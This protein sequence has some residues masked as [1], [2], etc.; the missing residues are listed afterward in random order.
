MPFHRHG[1]KKAHS[2]EPQRQ[3]RRLRC[4]PCLRCRGGAGSADGQQEDPAPGQHS[5]DAA[6]RAQA[7]TGSLLCSG[8]LMAPFCPERR[9]LPAFAGASRNGRV[10]PSDCT[11]SL[12]NR[13]APDF[14][15]LERLLLG[16]F[17]LAG[18][19]IAMKSLQHRQHGKL[20]RGMSREAFCLRG[21]GRMKCFCR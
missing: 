11:G 10:F 2:A 13:M 3:L 8:R 14:R 17:S 12:Q 9:L 15:V 16:A 5:G 21:L 6:P 19:G 20:L 7:G 4:R 18:L 1:S